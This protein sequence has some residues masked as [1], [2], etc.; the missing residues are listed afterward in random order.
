MAFPT[1]LCRRSYRAAA[2]RSEHGMAILSVC[3][4][5]R[6]VSSVGRGC[7][8]DVDPSAKLH[9]NTW[10]ES[11]ARRRQCRSAHASLGSQQGVHG[12]ESLRP[13][14]PAAALGLEKV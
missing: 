5:P 11:V 4:T 14:A 8:R 3:V 7:G 6:D 9:T 12:P 10:R 13:H 2:T 1:E